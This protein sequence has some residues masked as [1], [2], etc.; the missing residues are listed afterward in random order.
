M[1]R[2]HPVRIR[3]ETFV[4]QDLWRYQDVMLTAALGPAL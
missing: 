1:A 3:R 4:L 2:F